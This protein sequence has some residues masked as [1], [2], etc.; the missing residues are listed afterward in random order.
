MASAFTNCVFGL[1]RAAIL[2]GAVVGAGGAVAGYSTGEAVTYGWFTQAVLA[3][4]SMFGWTVLA[5]R[6][7]T[8]D[9]A[10]DLS[11]PVDPQ[12]AHLAQDLGRAAYQLVPR[13]A[14]PLV[15]GALTTG[16]VLPGSAW[17][18][19]LGA[20]SQVLA[21]T[22]AFCCNWLVNLTS[23]W[24]VE[25]RGVMTLYLV[26]SNVLSGFLVPVPWFPDWLAV[27]A[28]AT[29]FPSMIQTP[30]DVVTG[31]LDVPGTLVALL[32]Q[33]AWVAA[34]VVVGRIVMARG[35]RTLVVQGG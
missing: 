34:A 18:Y 1:I 19:L 28:R 2:T 32:V 29:P 33:V 9:V 3:P 16:L 22:L 12:L 5:E 23:F 20:L 31:R 24:L 11:R 6:V 26:A 7:R 21:V 13:G 10:V 27:L 8:G 30:I 17:P 14:P 4:V 25:M 35:V 15:A